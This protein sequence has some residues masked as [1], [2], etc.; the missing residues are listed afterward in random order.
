MNVARWL[1]WFFMVILCVGL[2]R[3]AITRSPGLVLIYAGGLLAGI[4][5]LYSSHLLTLRHKDLVTTGRL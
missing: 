4:S 2:I 5:S 1:I 3:A